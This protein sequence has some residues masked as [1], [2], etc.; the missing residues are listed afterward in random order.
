V[1]STCNPNNKIVGVINISSKKG[2]AKRKSG[3][4]NYK[5]QI[6]HHTTVNG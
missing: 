3:L 6:T 5:G 1:S 4:L 2:G